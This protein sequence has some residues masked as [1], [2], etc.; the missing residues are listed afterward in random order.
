[1]NELVKVDVMFRQDNDGVT[2]VFPYEIA[3]WEGNCTCYAHL[4]QHS[5]CCWEW[6]METKPATE[7]A[8]LKC[9][10]ESIGY[11][12]NVIHRRNYDKYLKELYKMRGL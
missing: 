3:D 11:I 12:V 4:G 2:A 9:E 1:M 8:E 6:V 7:Y 5:S 10:L